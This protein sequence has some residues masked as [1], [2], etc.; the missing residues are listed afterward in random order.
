MSNIIDQH[1]Q[2]F[3]EIRR[4]GLIC[5]GLDLSS[6]EM[7]SGS[8]EYRPSKSIQRVLSGSLSSGLLHFAIAI[9]VNIYQ[10]S[11]MGLETTDLPW[12]ASLYYKDELKTKPIN[13]KTICDKIIHANTVDKSVLPAELT[14]GSKMCMQFVG[15]HNKREW[16]M[17]IPVSSFVEYVFA[18]LDEVESKNA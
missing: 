2:T 3:D 13:L 4:I 17:D 10:S 9:R 12:W 7:F 1:V 8:Q 6:C 18:L 16:V 15:L 5:H 11:L 14:R